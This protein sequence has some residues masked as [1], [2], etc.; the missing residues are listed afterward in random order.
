MLLCTVQPYAVFKDLSNL[1]S[2]PMQLS[3]KSDLGAHANEATMFRLLE[4]SACLKRAHFL[5]LF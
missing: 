4:S 2:L 5:F 1:V 3:W